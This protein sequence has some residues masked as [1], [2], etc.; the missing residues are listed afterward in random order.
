MD[1][2][3]GNLLENVTLQVGSK[4]CEERDQQVTAGSSEKA[5]LGTA[6]WVLHQVAQPQHSS[7]TLSKGTGRWHVGVF[8]CKMGMTSMTPSQAG[9]VA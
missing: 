2:H 3:R 4:L 1:I 6:S 7:A 9:C 5:C 8:L